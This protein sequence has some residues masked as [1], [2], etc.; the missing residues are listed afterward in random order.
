MK[1]HGCDGKGWVEIKTGA[2]K[3]PICEGSGEL[4]EMGEWQKVKIPDKPDFDGPIDIPKKYT[5]PWP[6]INP[7]YTVP[8]YGCNLKS[9]YDDFDWIKWLKNELG[10]LDKE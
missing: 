1:C 3:C 6:K 10:R 4:K 5:K 8:I 7:P 2:V 9:E